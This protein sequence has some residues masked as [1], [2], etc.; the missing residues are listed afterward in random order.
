MD[1][2]LTKFANNTKLDKS[3]GCWMRLE[4]KIIL[5]NGRNGLK[6]KGCTQW[7]QMSSSDHRWNWIFWQIQAREC[8]VLQERIWKDFSRWEA[9]HT[10]GGKSKYIT[11]REDVMHLR[12]QRTFISFMK[13]WLDF[14]CV[15]MLS[16]G[17]SEEKAVLQR[18]GYKGSKVADQRFAECG[19]KDKLEALGSMV[20]EKGESCALDVRKRK[21]KVE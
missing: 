11:D 16:V 10:L 19:L 12:W 21:L 8:V 20:Q 17:C 6:W 18:W 13:H 7:D 9:E 2:K 15:G 1:I 3:A 4:F 5:A 14:I